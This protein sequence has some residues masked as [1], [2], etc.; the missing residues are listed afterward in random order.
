MISCR[1]IIVFTV[2]ICLLI[3][4]QAIK[5]AVESYLTLHQPFDIFTFITLYRTHNPG[6]SF[7][8]LSNI[9]PWILITIRVLIIAFITFIWNKT[10]KN[11]LITNIGYMLTIAGALGNLMDNCLYGYV[12]DYLMIHTNTWSF[13]IFNFADSIISIG[14]CLIV[15][16][17]I[18]LWKKD[19]KSSF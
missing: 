19:K 13:A 3:I 9:S 11:Q 14:A 7:S 18:L 16:N 17:E 2:I 6:V 1:Y 12:V 8:M 15:Y 10:P 5:I 4:D